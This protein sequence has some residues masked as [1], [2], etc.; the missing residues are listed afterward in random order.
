MMM[1]DGD[2][3]MLPAEC[4]GKSGE[5]ACETKIYG[6]KRAGGRIV[7]LHTTTTLHVITMYF[8]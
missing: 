4:N 8:D 5:R 6:G 2:D 3:E 7:H 1:R